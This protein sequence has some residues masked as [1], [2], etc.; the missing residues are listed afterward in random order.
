MGKL[1]LN[2]Y[3]YVLVASL[4]LN[5]PENAQGVSA[6]RNKFRGITRQNDQG[7][8]TNTHL[9]LFIAR[10]QMLNSAYDSGSRCECGKVLILI[11]DGAPSWGSYAYQEAEATR[12]E[13]IMVFVV[14]TG[15]DANFGTDAPGSRTMLALYYTGGDETKVFRVTNYSELRNL[16]TTLSSSIC[17]GKLKVR[18][19]RAVRINA[20]VEARKPTCRKTR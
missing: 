8:N 13:G 15:S 2:E 11:T 9:A 14:G 5:H 3:H 7:Y 6:V 10:T 1:F 12:K 16:S 18:I 17:K 20:G 19:M 4:L